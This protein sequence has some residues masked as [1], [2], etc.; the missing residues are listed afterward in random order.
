MA[1]LTICYA[2]ES[3][4]LIVA[5][6]YPD[7]ADWESAKTISNIIQSIFIACVLVGFVL[8]SILFRNLFKKYDQFYP[9]KASQITFCSIVIS[10][11][12][13]RLTSYIIYKYFDGDDGV[14]I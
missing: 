4:V 14:L 10:I 8:L 2:V 13:L 7:G 9:M 1:L 3:S 6:Y 5:F 12:A 11:S